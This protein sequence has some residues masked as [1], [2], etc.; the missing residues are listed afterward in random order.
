[1]RNSVTKQPELTA[2]LSQ[3][4]GVMGAAAI[5]AIGNV[6]SRL[7]GMV[8]EAVKA[9]LFGAS[10]A[11]AAF[12]AAALV[13]STL[14]DLIIGGIVSSALVPVFSDYASKEQREA[15]WQAVS[16]VVSVVTVLLLL[17]VG[18]VELFTPQV[19]WLVG[20]GQFDDPALA[21]LSLR[22]MRLTT[23]ALLFL[24]LSSLLTGVLLALKRFTLPAFTAAIFNGTIVVFALW[25]R[26]IDGLVWG[27]LAGAFLQMLVQ[28]PALRDVRLRWQLDWHHPAL[29]R[30]LKLYIPIVAGLVVDIFVRV[31]SYNL[32]I[33]TGDENLTYMRWATT[34][35]QFP[36]G[37]VVTALSVAILP[38]LSRQATAQ[39]A[40][41]KQTL[42]GG[43]RLVLVLILPATTGLFALAVPI[44]ALLFQHGAFTPA[45]T[46]ITAEVLRIY[47]LGLPFAAVDQ[48]L[49]FASYARKDTLRPAVV[50]VV[51]M[52][53]YTAAALLLI[54]PLGLLSLMVADAVKH[55]VHTLLM[56]WLL[57]REWGELSGLAVT[58]TLL[59]S[60]LAAGVMGAAAYGLILLLGQW[61]SLVGTVKWLLEVAAAGTVS[62]LLYLLLATLLRISEIQSLPRLLLVRRKP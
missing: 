31:L 47:L 30:I 12:E 55:V 37:L 20:A 62:F 15:L 52:V 50:G 42:A 43:I 41:F 46:N 16:A 54:R 44:V 13:P 7:I 29:R 26:T 49:V 36:M 5:L 23:P 25:W 48:M 11:L 53:V 4:R 1:M 59:K 10:G 45:D 56:L 33:S 35:I 58:G 40:E 28:L 14:F 38:T 34:L 60:T 51:S 2:N 19:A 22:L 18:L 17:V 9:N 8:R 61:L 6:T 3:D 24:G 39:L 27:L 21:D 32:A 57:R